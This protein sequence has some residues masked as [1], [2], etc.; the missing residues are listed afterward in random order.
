MTPRAAL[1]IAL[2]ALLAWAPAVAAQGRAVTSVI[3]YDAPA[4][5]AGD[6]AMFF[7]QQAP[8]QQPGLPWMDLT[9]RHVTATEWSQEYEQADAGGFNSQTP[10][11]DPTPEQ[12]DLDD[13]H[14]VLQS[15][16]G[17]FEVHVFA[18]TGTLPYRLESNGGQIQSGEPRMG[19][20]GYGAVADGN[21]LDDGRADSPDF[22]FVQR[23]GDFV[24]HTSSA[25][26][27]GLHT[28]GDFIVELH[29]FT[30]VDPGKP[31]APLES[32]VWMTPVA[33]APP[34]TQQYA[35]HV[36]TVF[37]RLAVTGGSLDLGTENG[38]PSLF[39]AASQVSST[40]SGAVTLKD[41][42]WGNDKV[43]QTR[44]VVPANS[45][46]DIR[47]QGAQL[48]VGV[49]EA[50]SSP[51]SAVAH[52]AGPASAAL[53]GT[54][55]VLALAAAVGVG[56]VRRVLRMPALADVERA[57]EEGEYRR[58]ARMAARILGRLPGSE[59][60]LLGRAIA[61][62]K[63]GRAGVVVDELSRRLSERPASDGT[64]HYVLGLAQLEVGN[65]D[66]GHRSLREAVRLTPSLQA[67]VLPR[68]GKSF[69]PLSPTPKETHG[70]A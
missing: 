63:D 21:P 2:L 67:E 44:A 70:Y 29:G 33:G 9:A 46:L 40:H 50:P 54:G 31:G 24:L 16:Q 53:V 36:R 69:S 8:P 65:T 48:A 20:G 10:G 51:L 55:A 27:V 13:A 17:S 34:S 32:G 3:A 45:V 58:A 57:L 7:L 66:D 39:W 18:P 5:Q 64:L 23:D 14:L 15:F 22:T 68:L 41:V 11:N 28:S 43:Q 6:L 12:R 25:P 56:V 35:S 38:Q 37:L 4:S 60:A 42:V 30:L 59:E 47:P 62:S 61:L 26:R 19:L 49:A 1:A 52:V